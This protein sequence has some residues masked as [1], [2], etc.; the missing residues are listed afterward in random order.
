MVTDF[1]V[2]TYFGS[3][4]RWI[5]DLD[6]PRRYMCLGFF[7]R[8]S[9]KFW[10]TQRSNSHFEWDRSYSMSGLR[11]STKYYR[12]TFNEFHVEWIMMDGEISISYHLEPHRGLK[13]Q[14][15]RSW[16]LLPCKL[17]PIYCNL[18]NLSSDRVTTVAYKLT[19]LDLQLMTRIH[20]YM[21]TNHE[22]FLCFVMK[23]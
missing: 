17:L 22:E 7:K 9:H 6:S 10:I 4:D 3:D 16:T 14:T 13:F 8:R 20:L 1:R 18:I 19:R 21:N 23:L 15:S 11:I 12:K 5:A 2:L